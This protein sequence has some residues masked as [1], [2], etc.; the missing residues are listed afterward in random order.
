MKYARFAVVLASAVLATAIMSRT[1]DAYLCDPELVSYDFEVFQTDACGALNY[2]SCVTEYC[3]GAE[4]EITCQCTDV[5]MNQN[6]DAE[7]N[8]VA[9]LRRRR[10]QIL[11]GVA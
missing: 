1:A 3:D 8:L 5:A 2:F 9:V 4:T 10:N 11:G 7:R 6:R